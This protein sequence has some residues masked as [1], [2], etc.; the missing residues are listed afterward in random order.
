MDLVTFG[1]EGLQRARDA[2]QQDLKTNLRRQYGD[3]SSVIEHLK[4]K[5]DFI[6]ANEIEREHRRLREFYTR[7]AGLNGEYTAAPGDSNMK[8]CLIKSK[9]AADHDKVNKEL[10]EIDREAMRQ[11][12]IMNLKKMD[13]LGSLVNERCPSLPDQYC[14]RCW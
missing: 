2:A 13:N 4:N 10:N 14:R 5:D 1:R 9:R 3:Y 11:L 6:A 7:V 12:A 8:K